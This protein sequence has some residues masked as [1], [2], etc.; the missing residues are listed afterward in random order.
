VNGYDNIDISSLL[1]SEP[2][3]SIITFAATS[4]TAISRITISSMWTED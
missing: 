1:I 2:A 3:G 4:P